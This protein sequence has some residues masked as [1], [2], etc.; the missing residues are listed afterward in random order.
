MGSGGSSG[1]AGVD[2]SGDASGQG[3]TGVPVDAGER[4]ARNDAGPDSGRDGGGDCATDG[5]CT[6]ISQALLVRLPCAGAAG[7]N[8]CTVT[9]D[10]SASLKID[11][12]NGTIYD[13]MLHIRG[14]VETKTYQGAC[15]LGATTTPASSWVVGGSP[16][17][18]TRNVF[19]LSIQAFYLNGSPSKSAGTVGLDFHESV[20]VTGGATIT[21][22]GQSINGVQLENVAPP[23]TPV[24]VA[25][26]M[27]PQP[28]DGQFIQVD[29]ESIQ[30]E[31]LPVRDPGSAGTAL[32]FMGQEAV[33]VA[34]S[35]SLQPT[36]LTLEAWVEFDGLGP[37]FGTIFGR[38]VGPAT[39]DS[40]AI[41]YQK[42]AFDGGVSLQS[43]DDAASFAWSLKLIQWHHLAMTYDSTLQQAIFY[44][45]GVPS[46][47]HA[48]GV[49]P[50]YDT[51]HPVY[52]GA[53]TDYGYLDGYWVGA[54]DEMR[55]FSRARTPE[56]VWADMHTD[57]LG[58]SEGLAAEWTFDEGNGSTAADSSGNRNTAVL[59]AMSPDAPGPSWTPSGVPR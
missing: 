11:G 33:T 28:Y 13:V 19:Q 45:D 37:D 8:T 12:L 38:P 44:L 23:L 24:T 22:A 10:Q 36:D 50:A 29:I 34:D 2:V 16:G 35:P 7:S 49:P 42:D 54:L 55:I 9:G 30:P 20:R 5:G 47:C 15:Q 56:E 27:V 48:S 41:W 25:G 51:T 43:A 39:A 58:P 59:G 21:L 3:D 26:T 57:R 46:A 32:K 14:V 31:A 53:D 1:S 6:P 4:D 52:L 18:D 40:Y 17:A